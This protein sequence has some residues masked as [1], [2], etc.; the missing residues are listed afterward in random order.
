MVDVRGDILR[1]PHGT[2]PVAVKSNTRLSR[3]SQIKGRIK[4]GMIYPPKPQG[5][6]MARANCNLFCLS[7][8]SKDKILW[9]LWHTVE[10][11]IQ[12]NLSNG[13]RKPVFR[14]VRNKSFTLEQTFWQLF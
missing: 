12:I 9:N 4:S 8:L 14:D 6:V 11:L 1:P 10:N 7:V 3:K 13:M 2:T 5:L